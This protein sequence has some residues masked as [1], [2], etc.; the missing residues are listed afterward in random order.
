MTESIET[1]KPKS[2]ETK[3]EIDKV[4]GLRLSAEK[5]KTDLGNILKGV[6]NYQKSEE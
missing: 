2:E 3:A 1:M 6:R 4:K 5:H